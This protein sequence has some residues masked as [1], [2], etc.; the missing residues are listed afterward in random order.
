MIEKKV[1]IIHSLNML[2]KALELEKKLETKCYVPGRDTNQNQHGDFI[3]HDNLEAMKNCSDLV[4]CIWDGESY[5]TLADIG[6]CYALGKTI[7]PYQLKNINDKFW[8]K[9][10]KDKLDNKKYIKYEE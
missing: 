1:F 10:F 5:G 7:I 9:F 6:S 2:D 4:Y 8:T 3:L